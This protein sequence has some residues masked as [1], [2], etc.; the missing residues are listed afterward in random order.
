MLLPAHCIGHRVEL[1]R[2]QT[3]RVHSCFEG[4]V[5]LLIEGEL[6]SL[7]DAARSDLPFGIRL[8]PGIAPGRLA[9]RVGDPVRL[10]AGYLAIGPLTLDC[11]MA[12]RWWPGHWSLPAHGLAARLD[13]VERMAAPRAW[14]DAAGMAVAVVEA[15][16]QRGAGAP[17][18]LVSAVGRVVGRGPGLTPAGDDVLAGILTVLGSAAAGPA[19][20][21][22]QA[23]LVAAVTPWLGTTGDI[24]RHL[25]QQ[26]LRGWS[27]RA[28]HELG[29]AVVEGA[30][31]AVLC[32]ALER[33]LDSGA[34]SGA[35]GCIG[36]VAACRRLWL[37]AARAIA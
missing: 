12:A 36:L 14:R 37:P 4:S 35:D 11:R 32:S 27:G 26:A 24:S 34:S 2:P 6:W 1:N 30:D 5:N 8:A 23:R 7:L 21:S 17:A 15:L 28:L 20:A 10:R 25:L 3:G 29:Q 22:M 31:E 18:R 33:L 9:L 16:Q 19:A 13:W